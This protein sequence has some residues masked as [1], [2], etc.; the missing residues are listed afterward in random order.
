MIWILAFVLV[1]SIAANVLLLMISLKASTKIETYE[2][3]IRNMQRQVGH[4]LGVFR[5]VDREGF[6]ANDDY[7]G[8]AFKTLKEISESLHNFINKE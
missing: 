6:F 5:L 4:I 8:E 7:V 3:F 1:L 2:E